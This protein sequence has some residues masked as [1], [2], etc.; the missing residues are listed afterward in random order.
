MYQFTQDTIDLDE[1]RARLRK[2]SNADLTAFGKAARYICS[3]AANLGKQPREPFVIQL[4]EARMEWRRRQGAKDG[5]ESC[6]MLQPRRDW[7]SGL[8]K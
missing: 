5:T 8:W 1:L 4:R 7:P 3:P 6:K 2:M